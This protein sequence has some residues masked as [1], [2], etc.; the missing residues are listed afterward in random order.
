MAR[1]AV[2][3]GA[4]LAGGPFA[5][6]ASGPAFAVY[7]LSAGLLRARGRAPGTVTFLHG[8]END[9]MAALHTLALDARTAAGWSHLSHSASPGGPAGQT[10][11]HSLSGRSTEST[12]R[13]LSW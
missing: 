12:V 3:R 13:S 7:A 1:L 10:S 2:L 6:D 4:D 11:H 9:G 8:G 5:P